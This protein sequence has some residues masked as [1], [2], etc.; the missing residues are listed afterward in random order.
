[1]SHSTQPTSLQLNR[2]L[3]NHAFESWKIGSNFVAEKHECLLPGLVFQGAGE[4]VDFVHTK[5]SLLCNHLVRSQGRLLFVA[6]KDASSLSLCEVVVGSPEQHAG[7]VISEVAGEIM[8]QQSMCHRTPSAFAK[9]SHV[10]RR[11]HFYDTVACV[12]PRL[13]MVFRVQRSPLQQQQTLLWQQQVQPYMHQWLSLLCRLAPHI[14]ITQNYLQQQQQQQVQLSRRCC[15][16][17]KGILC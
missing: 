16:L 9:S 6:T 5:A 10:R 8:I 14:H 4:A 1:M 3:Q 15:Q 2:Q 17:G 11:Y 12:Q 13:L 7:P